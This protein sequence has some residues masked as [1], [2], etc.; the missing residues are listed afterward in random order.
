MDPEGN[1]K[2]SY[3]TKEGKSYKDFSG[4]IWF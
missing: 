3:V 4:L 1:S 2:N